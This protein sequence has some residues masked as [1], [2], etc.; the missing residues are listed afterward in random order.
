MG[1]WVVCVCLW[2]SRSCLQRVKDAVAQGVLI[3]V[4]PLRVQVPDDDEL[5]FFE[6]ISLADDEDPMQADF[7][8]AD[9]FRML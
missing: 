8:N 5:R 1:V 7:K 3:D 2:M 4:W 9:F 6:A